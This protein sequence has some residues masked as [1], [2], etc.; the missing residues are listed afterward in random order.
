M[1]EVGK[2]ADSPKPQGQ[3]VPATRWSN[4]I[5][6]AGMTPRDDGE[7]I[8]KGPIDDDMSSDLLNAAACVATRNA[9]AAARTQLNDDED[10]E[11]V[12][13]ATVFIAANE[14]FAGHSTVADFASAE[15]K[16]RLPHAQICARSAVGVASLPGSALLEIEL[17]V[18]AGQR[19]TYPET[20]SL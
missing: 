6:T 5:F 14:R 19:H 10:V 20:A 12:L 4:L 3:Y 17:I 11:R 16:R 13:K 1:T 7:L 9:L 18:A 2:V 15:I 8:A